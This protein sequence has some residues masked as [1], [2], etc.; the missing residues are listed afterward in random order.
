MNVFNPKILDASIRDV[1]SYLSD[2]QK[3]DLLLY[4][5]KCLHFEGRSRT[6]IENAIQS[7]LQVVTLSP[8]NIA[9]AR[10]LRAKARLAGGSPLGAHD[11][12]YNNSTLSR[13]QL[14]G[15]LEMRHMCC[16][17]LQ[18]ALAVEPDNPEAKALLHQ[19][20]VT[21]EKVM[22]I[23]ILLAPL[24][25]HNL[26]ERISAEIWREIALHLPRRDL[27]AL[28][29]IPHPLSRIAS[30]LLFWELDLHFTGTDGDDDHLETYAVD[31]R[32]ILAQ[33]DEDVR[34]AQ[35]S[36]DILTRII[37]D[38]SFACAVRTLRIFASK[39]DKDGSV[40]FQTG[41]LTNALPKLINL[42]NVHISATSEGILPVLRILQTS[43]PRLRG[44]SLK[45]P[46][47]PADLSLLEFRHLSHFAYT[48]NIV[49]INSSAIHSL[50]GQNNATLRTIALENPHPSPHWT[51]PASSLSIRNLT[52]IFFTGHFPAVT[53]AFSEILS[54]GRQLESF[55]ITCCSLE[56][57]NASS[58]FRSA[59]QANALP[60]L[61]HFAFSVQSIGRRTMDRDLF[62]AIAEFLRGR[63]SLHSLQ[64]I[65][66]EESI[67]H[68]VG[69]DAA[70]WGVLPSLEGLR[71]LKISYPS[72]L[73]PGLASWLIPRTVLALRLTIDYNSQSARDPIPFLNQLRHGIPPSLRFVGLSDVHVRSALAVVDHGFPMV[74]VVRIGSNYW[75]VLRK[76]DGSRTMSSQGA[77]HNVEVEQWPKRRAL[78]HATEWL[79]WLG[80]EDAMVRDP[81]SFSG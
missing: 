36:A 74:R 35:R 48:M 51:F 43:S 63:R 52:T 14:T 25:K 15:S 76:Q 26:K 28:L 12:L 65:A 30:Q 47:G 45:S 57:S 24:P 41:M 75:T 59:Q 62:P 16:S 11:G 1:A 37:V 67:Q 50:I 4:A 2:N 31:Q 81:S 38:P 56:C 46:D 78:Y 27:K 34:H 61:R 66:R 68:A 58:Q 55:N 60:F 22:T 42:R 20:S 40:A 6:V 49:S 10:I 19:R 32:T 39:R 23:Y 71:G 5:M 70:I 72:D 69:F 80:C 3:V 18:A 7:C 53:N 9:K 17:D 13:I 33:K 21:V 73:A 44:L 77:G 29:F 79:E 64:L 54:N 8:E